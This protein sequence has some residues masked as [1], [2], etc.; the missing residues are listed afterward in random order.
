MDDS[1]TICDGFKP[2]VFGLGETVEVLILKISNDWYG[3]LVG[4][5]A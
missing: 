1:V 4:D 5:F 3:R 2:T